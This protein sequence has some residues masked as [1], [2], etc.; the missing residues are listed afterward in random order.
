MLGTSPWWKLLGF[1]GNL[2]AGSLIPQGAHQNL[3][4]HVILIGIVILQ[5][6]AQQGLQCKGH[7]QE[8]HFPGL[9]TAGMSQQGPGSPQ[10]LQHLPRR[11][12]RRSGAVAAGAP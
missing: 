11:C 8:L 2:L 10:G 9:G 1:A 5:E 3:R 6:R 12:R 7:E 4:H